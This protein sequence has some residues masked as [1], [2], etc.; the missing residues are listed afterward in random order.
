MYVATLLLL[1]Y[2]WYT[3][4]I[5]VKIQKKILYHIVGQIPHNVVYYTT[6]MGSP[7]ISILL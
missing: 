3:L 6:N 2:K 5:I 1:S 4:L 7:E